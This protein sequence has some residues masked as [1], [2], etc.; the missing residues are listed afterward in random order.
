ML[1][2]FGTQSENVLLLI[3]RDFRVAI[4]MTNQLAEN[5]KSAKYY[6]LYTHSKIVCSMYA[7]LHGSPCHYCIGMRRRFFLK[8]QVR[9]LLHTYTS[10]E[11]HSMYYIAQSEGRSL[12]NVQCKSKGKTDAA[13]LSYN[14]SKDLCKRLHNVGIHEFP[15][16]ELK[17]IST[18]TVESNAYPR[19]ST[20]ELFF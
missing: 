19:W 10:L 7:V 9:P 5:H 18:E 1:S 8:R 12:C 16:F 14:K 17:V 11:V 13:K 2:F 6:S 3:I 4:F 20:S 15:Y